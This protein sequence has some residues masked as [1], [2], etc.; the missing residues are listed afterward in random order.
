M[1]SDQVNDGEVMRWC[2]LERELLV[3]EPLDGEGLRHDLEGPGRQVLLLQG[4]D[5]Q[6][7]VQG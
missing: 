4:L 3:A 5:L 6:Q 1:I 7:G 2:H